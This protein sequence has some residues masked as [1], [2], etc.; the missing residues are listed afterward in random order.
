MTTSSVNNSSF[1]LRADSRLEAVLGITT[2]LAAVIAVLVSAFLLR[3]SWPSLHGTSLR[4][5]LLD[6]GWN[7][8]EGKFGLMPMVW[9]SVLVSLG[10]LALAGPLGLGAAIFTCHVAPS[11]VAAIF[12][13]VIALMAGIPSVVYGFWGLTV[14]VPLITRLAPPG[15]SLLAGIL[16]L[17]MMILPTVAL[18]CESA[19]ESVPA[20]YLSGA[21]ALG[22]DK[23]STVL[24]VVVPAVRRTVVASLLLATGRALGETMAVIMVAGNIV[25]IPHSVFDP[26]R[27]L[28]AN[29]AMEMAYATGTHRASLFV[30]GLLLA[31]LVGMLA[32]VA[33]YI[34]RGTRHA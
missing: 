20:S 14:V 19:I 17:A 30:S 34:Q 32:T 25:Q 13:R 15:A 21:A 18:L 6:D 27:T 24:Y 29:I 7:P 22:L 28:T 26:V 33:L 23:V 11:F 1:L 5:Y 10:A 31:G 4:H 8:L 9:A 16:I 3:E 2:A 12:R